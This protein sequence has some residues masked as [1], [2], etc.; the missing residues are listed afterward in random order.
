MGEDEIG[1]AKILGYSHFPLHK[2]I[3]ATYIHEPLF[4]DMGVLLYLLRR[5]Y[6]HGSHISLLLKQTHIWIRI[7]K[8][9][10]M[11]I[12]LYIDRVC[13]FPPYGA[14]SYKCQI[15]IL[16]KI[17]VMSSPCMVPRPHWLIK[18]LMT[19]IITMHSVDF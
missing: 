17:G 15:R 14:K 13:F 6:A 2:T 9:I 18:S 19:L 3:L 12:N 11:S 7:H 1:I 5:L 4:E 8:G 10:G 16:A